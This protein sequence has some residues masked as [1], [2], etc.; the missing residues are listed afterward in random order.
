MTGEEIYTDIRL[1]DNSRL[2]RV[3]DAVLRL[4]E[5]SDMSDLVECKYLN[6]R[7]VTIPR[8]FLMQD[9]HAL[10]TSLKVRFKQLGRFTKEPQLKQEIL[11]KVLDD[12]RGFL[13]VDILETLRAIQAG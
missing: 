11:V 10:E 1:F 4:L 12:F 13:S 7:V 6:G 2:Q 5:W 3:V 9:G 8:S